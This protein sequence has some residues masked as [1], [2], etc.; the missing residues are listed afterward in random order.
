MSVRERVCDQVYREVRDFLFFE[1][2]L[3]DAGCYR[4]WLEL[5]TEDV[6]Y[7][8][9]VRVTRER[10]APTDLIETMGHMD[11]DHD[12][13]EMRV[14]RLDTEAAW[15]EDPPSRSRHFVTNIRVA[16]GEGEEEL[17]VRSNLL[18]YRTRGDI[19]HFDMV[20]C[21]RHDMLRR[22]EGSLRL[23][24]RRVILDQSTALTHNFA[25]IF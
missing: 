19:P 18:L 8:V 16:T 7:F 20:S 24:N 17:A 25:L 2:E 9:P 10:G 22:E 5:V 6:H 4:E 3:L 1:A 12:S 14:L 13:L 23:A 11:E 15:A 21:E